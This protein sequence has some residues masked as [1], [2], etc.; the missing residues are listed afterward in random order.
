MP[1]P[2]PPLQVSHGK[3]AGLLLPQGLQAR[4]LG[5]RV[6]DLGFRVQGLGF[7]GFKV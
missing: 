6:E 2:K 4:P 7:S 3:A 5:F 1:P